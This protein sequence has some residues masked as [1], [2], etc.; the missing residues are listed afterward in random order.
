MTTHGVRARRLGIAALA[1]AGIA[2]SLYMLGFHG[3]LIR[4]LRCPFFGEGC[5]KVG[6]SRHAVHFGVPNAA[7]GAVG[8]ASMAA[9]ALWAGDRPPA[10]SALRSLGLGA[11]ATA[12][13]AASVYLTYE[14]PTKVGA[15][16][17][18][19]LSSAAI[20]AAVVTLAVPDALRG[21]R[22]LQRRAAS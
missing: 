10:K 16:C 19:C 17:F 9:L 3:G 11:L 22:A 4:H 1:A 18:W 21:A 2:D 7:A 12:A 8:Y 13:G 14:Q 15:W 6:R 5:D 20:N